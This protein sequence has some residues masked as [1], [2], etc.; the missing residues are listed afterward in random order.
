MLRGGEPFPPLHLLATQRKYLEEGLLPV[1]FL[2][3]NIQ[4]CL[5]PFASEQNVHFV[6][7]LMVTTFNNL[8]SQW[9]LVTS[10][11]SIPTA[12]QPCCPHSPDS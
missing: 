1:T 5:R 9:V 7:M 3:I 6:L 12:F 11:S 4:I 2:K 8:L 10:D